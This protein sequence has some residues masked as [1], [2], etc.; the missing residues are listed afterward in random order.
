MKGLL[1]KIKQKF[2]TIFG[3][4][5]KESVDEY[6]DRYQEEDDE[7][8]DDYE[9]EIGEEEISD[10]EHREETGEIPLPIPSKA[11]VFFRDLKIRFQSY[12]QR[13]QLKPKKY[14]SNSWSAKLQGAVDWE[15]IYELI[16]APENRH[17][18]HR[19]F[20]ALSLISL[21]YYTGKTTALFLTPPVQDK[22]QSGYQQAPAVMGNDVQLISQKDLF[23]ATGTAQ[24]QRPDRPR[25]V[26]PKICDTANS[27]SSLPI[28]LVNT[29]VLQD[30]V[31]SIASVQVRGGKDLTEI[32]EGEKLDNMAEIGKID[33]LKLVFKNL[34]TGQC[35]F[36]S[37]A[38]PKDEKP[39]PIN[40]ISSAQGQKMIKEATDSG[41]SNTGNNFKI[42]KS[43]R[44]DALKNIGDILTQARAIQIKNPDGSLCFKM[45]EVVPGSL[46]SKL[47]IQDEDI[48]CSING[49]KIENLNEVMNLFGRIR[50][51]DH[52]E[53]SVQRNG[54]EQNLEYD[55]E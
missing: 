27:R 2:A 39:N 50:D 10:D 29:T 21:F 11:H 23:D 3:R 35:E 37:G 49:K 25:D 1:N 54:M 44:D 41:I 14:M 5:S 7:N 22:K 15:K 19:T 51:I 32:R 16:T 26:G 46:Y 36:V 52:F 47:S 55:F 6:E 30:S 48:I 53:L 43:L 24:A 9:E 8:Q 38:D 31:K 34:Q 33:R 4:K 20:A 40:V 17:H 42:K 13:N 12:L 45:T 28:K 18:V